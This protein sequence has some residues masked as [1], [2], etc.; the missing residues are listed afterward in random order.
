MTNKEIL[1]KPFL[2]NQDIVKILRCSPSKASR[3]KGL[4]V[5]ELAKRGRIAVTTDIPTKL[6]I[7][8]MNLDIA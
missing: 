7:E 3:I 2:N 4:I 5:D 6:F 8:L 1:E